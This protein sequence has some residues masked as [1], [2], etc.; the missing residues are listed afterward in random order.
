MVFVRYVRL[1]WFVRSNAF[2]ELALVENDFSW[3]SL[4]S[5]DFGKQIVVYHPELLMV[6]L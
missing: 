6:Q 2:L 3:F 1:C 5:E 4:F